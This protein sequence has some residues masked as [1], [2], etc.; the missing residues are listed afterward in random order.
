ME[1]SPWNAL[2]QLNSTGF[3]SPQE[4][5][6]FQRDMQFSPTWGA[7]RRQFI[8]REGAAPNT[9]VGGD[10]NYR[11]AWKM[12][13]NPGYDPGSKEIHGYSSAQ[14]APY[15]TPFP[16]KEKNHPTMWKEDYMRQFRTNP[17]LDMQNGRL[18]PEQSDY[19]SRAIKQSLTDEFYKNLR[20]TR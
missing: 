2:K 11:A 14:L 12:G 13:A 9:N 16:F 17:D 18:T 4:E 19:I 1:N 20:L 10:Y 6:L 5:Q 3:T 15:A 8:A 7:W